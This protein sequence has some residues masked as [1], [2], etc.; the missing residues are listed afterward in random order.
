MVPSNA[1]GNLRF[2]NSMVGYRGP[3][4]T[5]NVMFVFLNVK[6]VQL[7]VMSGIVYIYLKTKNENGT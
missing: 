6:R 3:G 2:S 5:T 4:D 1:S 7:V